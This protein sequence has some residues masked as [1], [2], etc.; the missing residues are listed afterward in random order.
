[1]RTHYTKRSRAFCNHMRVGL[2]P[3]E[4]APPH[5]RRV[6]VTT[7]RAVAPLACAKDQPPGVASPPTAF[8]ERTGIVAAPVAQAARTHPGGRS[9]E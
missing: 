7:E 8:R 6:R 2:E 9:P 3:D 5:A 1:M 4:Q